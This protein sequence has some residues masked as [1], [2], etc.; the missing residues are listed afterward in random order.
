MSKRLQRR[1][2]TPGKAASDF[3]GHRARLR[4]RF[5]AGSGETMPDYELLELLLTYAIPRC[6]VK[7][8]AKRLL[9][10]F[11][12]L[13]AVF[14]ASV[15]ELTAVEGI[16]ESAAALLRLVKELQVATAREKLRAAPQLS[17]PAAVVEY[18]R[19]K[20]GGLSN[21]VFLVILLNNKN[22]V[23]DVLTMAEGTVDRAAVY[24]RQIIEQALQRHAKSVI[25]VHN[26][27]SGDTEPSADDI[28]LTREVTAAAQPLG[29]RVLDHLVIGDSSHRSCMELG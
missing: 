8:I 16:G 14:A 17:T 11:G 7:P 2:T 20:L 21:E 6:D 13:Q 26:H 22:R 15:S 5:I 25:M 3:I 4:K 18:A 10:Q 28:C 27:P 23:I 19:A 12:N 9:R 1:T 29:I 24:P